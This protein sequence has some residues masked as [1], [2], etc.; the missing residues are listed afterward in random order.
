M[1][2]TNPVAKTFRDLLHPILGPFAAYL[3]GWMYWLDWVLVMAAETAASAMF[4]QYW[5]S[6]VPLWLLSLIVSI[7]ITIVNLFQVKVYGETEYWLAGI[8]IAA[9]SLFILFGVGLILTGTGHYSLHI[10]DNL[11]AHGGLF[12]HGLSG[13]AA[14]MLVV[15]FSFGGTEMV[16]MTMGETQNPEKVIPRAAR[17][18]IVRIL[19]FYI[20]PILVILSLVPWSQLTAT[21]SPFVSVFTAVGI[22]YAGAIMNFVLFT[23]VVSATNTGMYAASRM[24][25][26]QALDGQAPAFFARLSNRGVP[27]RAL[28]V[29]T[30]FLYIGVIVA[31]FVKG[32][33]FGDLMV[34][35]GYSVL[36]VW[37]FICIAHIRHSVQIGLSKSL[38]AGSIFALCALTAI[39]IGIVITSPPAGTLVSFAAVLIIAITY[40]GRR[41]TVRSSTASGSQTK[42]A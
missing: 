1:T 17:T 36:L 32:Q 22:P 35:P 13:F 11:T 34:I 42:S 10:A 20:L 38:R 15:M 39:L 3:T 23:A 27:V 4:L 28:L 2:V 33:A 37:I 31:F 40:L 19:V 8:K 18:V 25:Y 30:S 9:L 16:G 21:Q 41:R 7:A 12:P 29:S 14:S 5:F 6:S 26:T 24:L